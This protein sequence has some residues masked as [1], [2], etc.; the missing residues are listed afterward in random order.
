MAKLQ[1]VPLRGAKSHS[2]PPPAANY[3]EKSGWLGSVR[4]AHPETAA[5]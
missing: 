4:L 2:G 1:F 5:F 3:T